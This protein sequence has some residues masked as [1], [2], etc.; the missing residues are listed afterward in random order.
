MTIVRFRAGA[1][2]V[3]APALFLPVLAACSSDGA[4]SE[5]ATAIAVSSTADGCEL[6][7]TTAPA[8]GVKFTVKNDGNEATEFYLYEEDGTTIVSEVENIG[9]GTSR[10]MSVDVKAGTYVTA[11]KPGQTGDGI[12]GD[13]TVS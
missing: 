4:S 7:A 8:G 11:C 13:F 2:L 9:P 6:S 3:A 12:R 5:G 10:D 1:A